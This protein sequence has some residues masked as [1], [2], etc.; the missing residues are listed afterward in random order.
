[1]P[2]NSTSMGIDSPSSSRW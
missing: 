1:M 2:V